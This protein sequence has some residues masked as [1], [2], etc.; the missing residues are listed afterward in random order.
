[1]QKSRKESLFDEHARK[2]KA[3][4]EANASMSKERRP[5]NREEDLKTIQLGKLNREELAEKAKVLGSRFGHGKDA[6]FL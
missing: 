4:E 3:E 5:F 6:R 1:M 2:R